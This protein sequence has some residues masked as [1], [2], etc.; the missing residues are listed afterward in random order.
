[1]TETGEFPN[2]A[3]LAKEEQQKKAMEFLNEVEDDSSW[4][5]AGAVEDLAV[6]LNLDGSLGEPSE[7]IAEIEKNL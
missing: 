7:I 6:W 2:I 5:D 1:M 4:E 3:G